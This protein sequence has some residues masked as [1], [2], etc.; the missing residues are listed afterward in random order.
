[1]RGGS[2]SYQQSNVYYQNYGSREVKN[3]FANHQ[4]SY[5]PHSDLSDDLPLRT[6]NTI[7]S[8]K[9]DEDKNGFMTNISV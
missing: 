7:M 5:D 9:D 1:M 6:I 8:V 3:R 4:R 2:Q